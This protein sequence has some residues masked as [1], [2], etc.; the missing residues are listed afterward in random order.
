MIPIDVVSE[1][2]AGFN[3]RPAADALRDVL[4]CCAV[5]AWARGLVAGRPYPDL[6][7]LVREELRRIALLRLK[8]LL[9]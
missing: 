3:A 4:A 8:G 9:A 1:A 6:D 5:S 7:A 2:V